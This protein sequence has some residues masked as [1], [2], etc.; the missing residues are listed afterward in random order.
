MKKFSR[1][2]KGKKGKEPRA[3]SDATTSNQ[4]RDTNN[5]AT[6]A[7]SPSS[8]STDQPGL[9]STIPETVPS[10]PDG[11][12]VWVD[13]P[14]AA[15]DICFVHGLSGDRDATWTAHGQS[16]PWPTML[17]PD[18]LPKARLLTYGY[19]AYVVRK[20]VAG[21]NRLID[22]ATN[23]L[24]DLTT[25]R[26][27][28]NAS[29]RPLI[30]VAHSLGGLVCK[31]AILL[32][33]NHPESHLCDVFDCVIGVIFMGTPH[34]GS[35]MAHWATVPTNALGF[36]KSTNK[37]LLDALKTDNQ[38]LQSTQSRF[39]SMVRG[40][41]EGG[42]HFQVTCFFEE[43]QLPVFGRVVVTRESATFESYMPLSIHADHSNMVKFNSADDNGFKRLLGELMRWEKSASSRQ[44]TVREA[45]SS[46]G[47]SADSADTVRPV[48]RHYA[49]P[50]ETV[51]SYTQRDELWHD[52]G[53]KLQMRH[54]KAGV[55]FAVAIY[56]LGGTGKSQ[57]ALK[58]A[59]S[60]KS[61][62]NPILWIDATDEDTT[63]SSFQR[64]ARALGLPQDQ[65]EKQSAALADAS[66]VQAV[67]R[68]LKGRTSAEDEWLVVIDNADDFNWGLKNVVP[69]GERG[70]IIITSQDDRSSML[71]PKGCERLHVDVMSS[72]EATT[73]LLQR[74]HWNTD[75]V[76]DNVRKNCEE[77][78]NKLEFLALAIDLAGAYISNDPN[79]EHAITQYLSDFDT[80]RNELLQ[81]NSFRGLLPT[82][83]TVWTVWDKTLQKITE[84][85][86]SLQPGLLL[87]FLA[88]FKGNIIQDEI[89]RLAAVGSDFLEDELF[90][91]L[92]TELWGLLTAENGKWDSFQYRQ[93]WGPL[94]RYSLLQRVDG[95]WPGVRMHGLV[96]WRTLQ[97]DHGRQ[98]PWSYMALITAACRQIE[99]EKQQPEFRRHLIVHIPDI[100]DA[101]GKGTELGALEC[102]IASTL[103][104]VYRG[105]GRWTQAEM[106]F[107]QVMETRKTKL[108]AD[109]PDTLSSMAELAL[110]YWDQGRW[111]EAEKLEVK[112]TEIRGAKLGAD[113]PDTLIS[114]NNLASTYKA[115]GRWNEAEKLQMQVMETRKMKLGADH[116]NTLISMNN[117]ASTYWNQ[118]R[119]NE[120]EKLEMQVMETRKTKLGAD[121]PGTLMSVANLAFTWKSQGRDDEAIELMDQCVQGRL[122]VL[123]TGHPDTEASLSALHLWRAEEPGQP[124]RQRTLETRAPRGNLGQGLEHYISYPFM[125]L[126]QLAT[127]RRDVQLG[128]NHDEI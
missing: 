56:G 104:L 16:A 43:L 68:W 114:M 21:T 113:H 47:V 116:P 35:W 123:P 22:H 39:L 83:K 17:L 89:F 93:N 125:R 80:H 118:G 91:K 65:T 127:I 46:R 72:S 67:L 120:A 26:A 15:F 85:Y 20:S 122:L 28:C 88:H 92:P 117:L 102:S 103:G 36:V 13:C 69:S 112:V 70:S 37:T 30:F 1:L 19:D 31:E 60:Y 5:S 58:Y 12:K 74:L 90:E 59:E 86:P 119:W 107:V 32:S 84:D 108:G 24:S 38:I 62:Y 50:L 101:F 97:N 128:G 33:R 10:F 79:P 124:E 61:R 94:V 18:K 78:V 27:L 96:Q 111:N 25:D 110:T 40:L 2:L 95:D 48:E 76:S 52:L 105:E 98:W 49:V 54:E 81:M 73:L 51:S 106:L 53:E 126:W 11:V 57:L 77:V 99:E 23:L 34:Q 71:I 64:C 9:L 121:H 29:S 45:V 100:H 4:Q 63:R 44:Q 7:L 42:K 14:D 6:S 109:H 3:T 115:Q 41:R 82:E 87:T 55:P 66:V 8:S 75:S